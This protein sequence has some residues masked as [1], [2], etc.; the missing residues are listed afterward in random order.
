[1]L[2][3]VRGLRLIY[4]KDHVLWFPGPPLVSSYLSIEGLSAY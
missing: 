3:R 1:M 2:M 4:P